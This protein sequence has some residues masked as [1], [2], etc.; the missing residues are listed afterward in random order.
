MAG[1]NNNL[2]MRPSLCFSCGGKKFGILSP[3]GHCKVSPTEEDEIA[4]S[5]LMTDHY[6]TLK[7]LENLSQQLMRGE[8]RPFVDEKTKEQLRPAIVEAQRLLNSDRLR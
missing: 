5:L 8:P 2:F 1:R 7:E 3:C 6:M 4:L